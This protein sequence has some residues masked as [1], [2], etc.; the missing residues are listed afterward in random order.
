VLFPQRVDEDIA[1]D[2]PMRIINAVLD[3]IDN[4]QTKPGYNL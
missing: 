3:G 1:E 4:G 2:D